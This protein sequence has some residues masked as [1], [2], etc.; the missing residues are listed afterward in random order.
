MAKQSEITCIMCPLACR[1]AVTIDDKGNV[2]KVTNH[3]CKRGEEFAEAEAKFP[4]RILT[5]TVV[6][7]KSVH[8]LLPVK[9]DKPVSKHRLMDCMYYL[10]EI[11]VKPPVKA[12]QIIAHNILDTGA[13]LV[14]TRD[15]SE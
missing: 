12:G 10:S 2:L 6:T 4:G 5:A 7:E 9:T 15:L 11:R 1:V 3:Q 8:S 13:D 14:A